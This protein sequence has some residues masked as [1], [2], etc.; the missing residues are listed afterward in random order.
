L[1][2]GFTVP[3]AAAAEDLP[4]MNKAL[5]AERRSDLLIDAMNLDQKIQQIAMKPVAN[6]NIF[7]CAFSAQGRHVEGIPELPIPTLRMTNGRSATATASWPPP[8]GSGERP[9]RCIVPRPRR[10]HGVGRHHR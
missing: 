3:T 1:V 9:D 6:T 8:H 7:N 10:F 4:R 2:L 5:S